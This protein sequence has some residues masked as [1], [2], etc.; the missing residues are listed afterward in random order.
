MQIHPRTKL[1]SE[2]TIDF[3]EFMVTFLKKHNQL[4]YAEII[5]IFAEEVWGM[6][7]YAVRAERKEDE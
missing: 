2:A 3:K 1:V 6:A 7:N 4:T 5:A